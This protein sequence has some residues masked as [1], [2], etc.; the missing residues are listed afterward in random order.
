MHGIMDY[1]G[2][3]RLDLKDVPFWSAVW[4]THAVSGVAASPEWHDWQFLDRQDLRRPVSG[5]IISLLQRARAHL[6]LTRSAFNAEAAEP[7]EALC[8]SLLFQLRP[9]FELS[10]TVKEARKQRDEQRLVFVEEQYEALDTMELEPRALFT[11]PAG[12]G[13][14]SLAIEAA[15]RAASRGQSVLFVCFNRLLGKHLESQFARVPEVTASTLHAHMLSLSALAVPASPTSTWWSNEL[16]DA[17]LAAT[18]E[19]GQEYD[20]LIVD[21]AQDLVA[22]DPYL[23]LLDMSLK[24]GLAGGRW[25]MFGDFERQTLY[26]VE[27]GRAVLGERAAH[28]ARPALKHNC[29]NTPQVALAAT[30]LSGLGPDVYRGYRRRDDGISPEYKTYKRR[31]DQSELLSAAIDALRRDQYGLEEIAVLSPDSSGVAATTCDPALTALLA[32]AVSR[33]KRA[34]YSTIYAYKGMDA[35]AVIVTDLENVTGTEAE[36]LLYVAL[37]RACD[38]LYVFAQ[39]IAMIELARVLVRGGS[40]A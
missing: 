25:L 8:H 18:M 7:S 36:A 1:L 11:G 26:G 10:L 12:T 17:A 22:E 33:G 16:P 5:T 35:P 34:A 13:K 4:F 39:E 37:S 38:R 2:R 24:C 32:P 20:V 27:D 19:G 29:R 40:R 6:K 28:F 31:E 30:Q 21:E 9:K 15:Q 14:T 23:D 3:R